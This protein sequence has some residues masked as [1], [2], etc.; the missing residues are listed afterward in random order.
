MFAATYTTEGHLTVISIDGHEIADLGYYDA[1]GG[2]WEVAVD[3]ILAKAGYVRTDAWVGDAAPLAFLAD[4]YTVQSF[5][6]EISRPIDDVQALVNQIIEIDGDATFADKART[7]L[8]AATC[9]TILAQLGVHTAEKPATKP[10]TNGIGED[11]T[12]DQYTVRVRTD[13]PIHESG[14][15]TSHWQMFGPIYA[16]NID[17]TGGTKTVLD[18]LAREARAAHPAADEI[19]VEAWTAADVDTLAVDDAP[20]ASVRA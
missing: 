1:D 18:R 12:V 19:V 14:G 3:G 8:T 13:E 4:G 17:T 7:V 15:G 2:S 5:A 16:R 11:A 20:V 6:A 9:E 10:A